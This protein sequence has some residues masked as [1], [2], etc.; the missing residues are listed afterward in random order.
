MRKHKP[1]YKTCRWCVR[2]DPRVS[3]YHWSEHSIQ[4]AVFP[5][6]A[7]LKRIERETAEFGRE[8][9]KILAG[10]G[11]KSRRRKG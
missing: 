5:G 3:H 11:R 10:I 1:R 8:I 6:P 2:P 4:V 9:R 7:L